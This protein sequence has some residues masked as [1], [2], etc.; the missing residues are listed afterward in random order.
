MPG[1]LVRIADGH[2]RRSTLSDTGPL[3]G[4]RFRFQSRPGDF[5]PF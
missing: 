2:L 4:H 5:E 1:N 3:P